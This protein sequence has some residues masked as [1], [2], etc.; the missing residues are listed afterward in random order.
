MKILVTGG[1]GFVGSHLIN[2]LV[3]DG[4]DIRALV[5]PSSDITALEE[6]DI[7]IVRGN[8][9]DPETTDRV[10]HGC[11]RVYH[12]AGEMLA[13]GVSKRRYFSINVDGT[14][15]IAR[16][17][18]RIDL[19]RMVYASSAGVYGVI[20]KPPVNEESN[21]N[22]SSAYRESK[23]LGEQAIHQELTEKGLPTVI[24]RL[25]GLMGPGSMNW[26]G[27]IRAIATDHFRIIGKGDNHDHVAYI[28]DVV[29]GLRLCGE[30]PGIDG[31]SYLIAGKKAVTVNQI[32]AIIAHELGVRLPQTHLPIAPFRIF[33]GLGES[34]YKNFGVELPGIHRYAIFLADKILDISK[35]EHDLGFEPKVSF[36]E[37]IRHSINWYRETNLI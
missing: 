21:I 11:Q 9:L 30:T 3:K 8:L 7:E 25:P 1:T 5:R 16:A 35:A 17:C 28:S 14:K 15:N 4:F 10:V 29:N 27:L 22:P 24:A 31:Q 18:A 36:D 32:V 34:L 23:W 6:L 26:L 12:M 20:K 13:A 2:S 33:N 37:G 19:D